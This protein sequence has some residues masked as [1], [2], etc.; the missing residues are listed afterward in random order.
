M[1]NLVKRLEIETAKNI[2]KFKQGLK[3]ETVETILNTSYYKRLITPAKLR[4]AWKLGELKNYLIERRTAQ[5]LKRLQERTER[6]TSINGSTRSIESITITVEWKKSQMWG[7]NPRA[8]AR[9]LYNN[10]T[11]QEFNSSSIGGC[12][13]DKES[14]AIAEALNQCPEL[15]YLMMKEKNRPCNVKRNN[16]EIFGY[17]SGY[18][19]FP[20]F[21]G[22]VGTSCYYDIFKKLKFKFKS[23]AGGKT[24][25]VYQAIK[26]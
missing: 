21:E 16:R 20:Q 23:I 9:V 22:G 13:Y 11:A 10:N 18:G 24:F 5:E 3:G 15:M 26:K 2:T 17:G 6:A 8:T 7:S 4:K 25:D 19:I 14:T 12:G 1:K